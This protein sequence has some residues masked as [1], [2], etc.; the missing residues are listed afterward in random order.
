MTS[1][2]FLLLLAVLA[3]DVSWAKLDIFVEP[4]VSAKPGDKVPLKCILQNVTKPVVL[5][6]LMVQWFT[7]GKQVAEFDDKIVI[8]KT[9]LS[10]SLEA[11]KTGDATLTIDSFSS[12]NAGNYRC[13]VYYKSDSTMKQTI[14]S[15]SSK[16]KEEDDKLTLCDSTLDKKLDNIINL[17]AKVDTKLDELKKCPK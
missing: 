5:K 14:L 8:S 16:P 17:I 12:E 1:K 10:M 6:D 13:Y 15:D 2:V 9:G 4:S 7:R 3:F 11:I